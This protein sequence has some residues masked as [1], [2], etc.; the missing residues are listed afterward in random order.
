MIDMQEGRRL[1][2]MLEKAVMG[3]FEVH[4]TVK[5]LE[6]RGQEEQDTLDRALDEVRERLA[7]WPVTRA[8]D[9][10]HGRTVEG[11]PYVIEDL[12][13]TLR[14]LP[15]LE[16]RLS[17][18]TVRHE[19]ASKRA[20]YAEEQNRDLRR[21]LDTL[22]GYVQRMVDERRAAEPRLPQLLSE[23]NRGCAERGMEGSMVNTFH[24]DPRNW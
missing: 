15:E 12:A 17:E 11:T 6:D 16:Q 21:D 8:L 24:Q 23:A 2:A 9:I 13:R 18:V 1:L 22:R 4:Q 14:R 20:H 5:Y 7:N 3:F 10:G 19:E